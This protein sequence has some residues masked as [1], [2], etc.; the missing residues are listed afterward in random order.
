ML[1]DF[2][3]N[4]DWDAVEKWVARSSRL[5]LKKLS[6]NDTSW[7]DDKDKHQAGVY[8][9]RRIRES[10]FFPPLQ[11][12]EDKPHIFQASCP[13]FWPQTGEFRK[14][15]MRHYSNKGPETHLTVIPHD[16]F[17][18][19][20]PASW[21]LG[22]HLKEPVSGAWYWFM[23][24]DSTS[25]DAEILET[26]LN[27]NA[28]FHYDIIDPSAL[29]ESRTLDKDASA[30]LI[31]QIDRAIRTGTLNELLESVAR[32]PP[33]AVIAEE[34]R[35]AYFRAHGI[36]TINPFATDAPG[37][38]VMLISRDYEY[39]IFKRYELRRRAVE[40]I[41]ALIR[42][43]SL[44]AAVVHGFAE[45]D[46]IFLSA[47]QQ[48]KTRA[49]RSF[50]YHLAALLQAGNIRFEE[51]AVLGGRRPDFVLPDKRTIQAGAK[52]G[53]LEAAILSAKTT[54]RERW[55]QITHERF[56]CAIFLATVDDRVSS[57]AL[58]EM[59]AADIALVVPESLKSSDEAVYY[60]H[61]N[62]ISF[63]DFF[64][65]EISAKRPNVL[66]PA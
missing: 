33:P 3:D 43:Q 1:F 51:Q 2:I 18:G 35:T 22:G 31:D 34:A 47:S 25:Q 56:N 36:S 42:Q 59:Q 15:G 49:G 7:A 53:Y 5:F 29:L 4:S 57:Q 66:R 10:A 38:A 60:N 63:R 19:L 16:I 17:K 12:R 48:R 39:Q 11:Q 54:L 44:T 28:D 8:I 55:K 41:S 24:I 64:R 45:L 14:S 9:P 46:S 30:E 61:E 37:D 27:I 20:N 52:R 50:E 65:F 6:R 21:L 26:A 58:G 13:T 40:V 23:V 32:L 62:V